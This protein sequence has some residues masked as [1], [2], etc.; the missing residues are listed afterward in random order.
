VLEKQRCYFV[1]YIGST[2][3]SALEEDAGNDESILDALDPELG[4][5]SPM[6]SEE[7]EVAMKE[8]D[9]ELAAVD[10]SSTA[11]QVFVTMT[12]LVEDGS[13]ANQSNLEVEPTAAKENVDMAYAGR[14]DPLPPPKPLPSQ[15]DVFPPETTRTPQGL[16]EHVRRI[17][18]HTHHTGSH[19]RD[20]Q[21]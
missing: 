19:Q 12:E 10:K 7:Y 1:H 18:S 6:N 13:N 15:E 20:N 2:S 11:Q 4:E 3:G 17:A 14:S 5:L 21:T 16:R 8:Y 9:E